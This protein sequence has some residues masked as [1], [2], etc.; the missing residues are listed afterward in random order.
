MI[1]MALIRLTAPVLLRNP[2]S[3]LQPA[4]LY[5]YLDELRHA[6]DIDGA[7]VEIGCNLGGTAALAHRFLEQ[8]GTPRRYVCVDTFSGFV[9]SQFDQDV[10]AGVPPSARKMFSHNSVRLVRQLLDQYGTSAVELIEG[11][12]C[13]LD[14]DTLPPK[15]AVALID[16]D[17]ALPIR[18]SLEALSPRMSPGGVIVVDDCP[19]GSSWAG[20]RPEYLRWVAEHGLGPDI[21]FGFGRIVAT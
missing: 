16:V 17:L 14:P 8:I 7:V 2:V 13:T 15:I 1:P 12:I 18:A 6:H 9:E 19:E 21:R 3:G 5:A 11:D 4:R 20:A 10:E